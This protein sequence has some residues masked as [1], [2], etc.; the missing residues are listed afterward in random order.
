MRPMGAIIIMVPERGFALTV[1]TNSDGGPKLLGDLFIDDWALRRFAGVSNLPARPPAL[2]RRELAPYEGI[3]TGQIID[4]VFSPS[5]TVVQTEIELKGTPN[6]RLRMRRTDS[7]DSTVLDDPSAVAGAKTSRRR[8][9]F[10][11]STATTTCSSWTRVASQ[12]SGRTSSGATTGVLGGCASAEDST[13]TR[14][15]SKTAGHGNRPS[16]DA[17]RRG[18][19]CSIRRSRACG[20]GVAHLRGAQYAD[21]EAEIPCFSKRREGHGSPDALAPGALDG[22]DAIHAGDPSCE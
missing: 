8:R 12:P 22:G 4:P 2:S 19:S 14:G 20:N 13:G 5:G 15:L 1:L 18:L 10:W 6:G 7:V 11:R 17:T 3:Y 9:S 16:P 21:G